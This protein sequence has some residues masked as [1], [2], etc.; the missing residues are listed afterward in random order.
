MSQ[1]SLYKQ[2]DIAPARPHAVVCD[3]RGREKVGWREGG[4]GGM[5]GERRWDGGREEKVGWRNEEQEG[6]IDGKGG[7]KAIDSA[8]K[9][10][11]AIAHTHTH[12]HTHTHL[13]KGRLHHL[14]F[15]LFNA[16]GSQICLQA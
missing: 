8:Y 11:I 12:T 4:E 7:H 16:A 15:H 13:L 9:Y 1:A 5:E 14:S 10:H 3:E 6:G 2:R